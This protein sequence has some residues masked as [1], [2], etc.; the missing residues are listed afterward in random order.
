MIQLPGILTLK[1]SIWRF[2]VRKGHPN[3]C[4]AWQ[5]CVLPL[6]PIYRGSSCHPLNYFLKFCLEEWRQSSSSVKLLQS[7]MTP[8]YSGKASLHGFRHFLLSIICTISRMV[9][10]LASLLVNEFDF[11]PLHPLLPVSFFLLLLFLFPLSMSFHV[12]EHYLSNFACYRCSLPLSSPFD[13]LLLACSSFP[14]SV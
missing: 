9:F 4:T 10:T 13:N 14:F 2:H 8:R 7:V 6:P 3:T 5:L 1:K 11:S 12:Y